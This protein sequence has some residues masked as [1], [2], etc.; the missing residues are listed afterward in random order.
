MTER[1]MTMLPEH[2]EEVKELIERIADYYGPV[3]EDPLLEEQTAE[4][5]RLTGR[6]QE[7]E[8]VGNWC[9]EYWS[10]A[11]LD[12]TAYFFF[13]GDLPEREEI[14]LVFW[15]LK[16]GVAM[17]P[18]ALYEKLRYIK[19][20]AKVKAVELLPMEEIVSRFKERFSDWDRQEDHDLPTFRRAHPEEPWHV[21]EIMLFG[22]E[23]KMLS[24]TCTNVPEAD[25]MAILQMM[26][27][28]GCL[29]YEPR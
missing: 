27:G 28:F 4:M 10:R 21:E 3:E 13:H 29:P 23:E 1:E 17:E 19:T 15:K 25:R 26:E 6:D 11:S 5:R 24:V 20:C 7:A 8:E 14:E 2:Y 16:P 22:Y 12:E 9:F 18:Q